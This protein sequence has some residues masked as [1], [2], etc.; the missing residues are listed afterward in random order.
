MGAIE[1]QYLAHSAFKLTT[2]AGLR[3]VIDPWRNPERGRWF[4]RTFPA[5]EANLVVI[6]HDHFDHDAVDRITGLPTVVRHAV[7]MTMDDLRI[8]GYA[9]WHVAGHSSAGLA[10]VIFLLETSGVR[11]CHL[12]DNRFPPPAEIVNAI[13]DVDLLIVPVDDSRHLLRYEE[14][15]GFIALFRPRAVIPVHYLISG[16]TAPESTLEPPHGWL[17]RHENIREIRGPVTLSPDRLPG[18][19][20][21][22]L[23]A[24]ELD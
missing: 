1:L 5:T 24:P 15:D 21:I 8:T 17:A 3:V 19:T 18:E 10:N 22:W 6:T 2:P 20:E 14:T 9:D 11:V 16:V 23:M 7:D 13:G 12:G 4:V